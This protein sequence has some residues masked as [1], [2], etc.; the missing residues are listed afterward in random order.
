[1]LPTN[2]PSISTTHQFF[3]YLILPYTA[4]VPDELT[5]DMKLQFWPKPYGL[6]NGLTLR[7]DFLD[8]NC[9]IYLHHL[10]TDQFRI[11]ICEP[12][13]K[14]TLKLDLEMDYSTMDQFFKDAKSVRDQYSLLNKTTLL[15]MTEKTPKF[16]DD[17]VAE[18]LQERHFEKNKAK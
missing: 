14:D 3:K 13:S 11:A 9:L 4:V 15:K 8:A 5:G 10:E 1:M 6:F 12:I 17:D 18:A 7:I 16:G 2:Q